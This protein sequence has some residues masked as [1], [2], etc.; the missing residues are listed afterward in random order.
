MKS[1]FKLILIHNWLAQMLNLKRVKILEILAW[2]K[3]NPVLICLGQVCL[4]NLHFLTNQNFRHYL[5][6]LRSKSVQSMKIL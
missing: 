4:S 6:F 3:I 2:L 5:P 1:S